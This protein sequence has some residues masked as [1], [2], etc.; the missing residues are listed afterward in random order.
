V[1]DIAFCFI[2]TNLLLKNLVARVRPYDE[3]PALVPLVSKLSDWSFPSGHTCASFAAAYSLTK[4][5]GKKGALSYTVAV[6]IAFSRLYVG[7][8]YPTDVIGGAIVGFLGSA[9]FYRFIVPKIDEFILKH[10]KV[11]T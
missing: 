2:I 9:V 10:K 3:I 7:V 1:L 6:L 4:S 8:H 11:K 5:Y